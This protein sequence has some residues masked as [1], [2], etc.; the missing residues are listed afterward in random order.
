VTLI[1]AALVTPAVVGR[2]LT[3]SFA[4]LLWIASGTGALCG[5]AGMYASYHLDVSSGATI[6]LVA[7]AVFVVAFAATG[8]RTRARV[9]GLTP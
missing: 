4:R 3:N 2:L 1:A 8:R 7:S 9:S 5:A 6:V